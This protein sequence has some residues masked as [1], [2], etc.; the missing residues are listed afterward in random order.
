MAF[1]SRLSFALALALAPISEA[2]V[3]GALDQPNP[4]ER[5]VNVVQFGVPSDAKFI[6]CEGGDCP[7]RSIKHLAVQGIV[8][9]VSAAPSIEMITLSADTLFDIDR[10]DLS[11]EGHARLKDLLA[12]LK[13]YPRH[14]AV[15]VVGHTD[16]SGDVAYNQALSERRADAVRVHLIAGGL[17]P[18]RIIAS[19]A[20]ESMPI[21]GND[22]DTGR[23]RNRRVEITI[24]V[25]REIH[26]RP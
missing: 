22:T 10:A 7:K 1:F 20:G 16:S 12:D 9:A 23:R 26:R 4:I 14:G 18:D 3:A 21:A 15:R 11:S 17:P 25:Q 13:A 8:Q 24:P 6:V 19:G 5:L 2:N